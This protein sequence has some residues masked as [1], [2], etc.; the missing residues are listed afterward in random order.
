MI[1]FLLE[2]KSKPGLCIDLSQSLGAVTTEFLLFRKSNNY[3][4]D[5]PGAFFSI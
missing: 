5:K 2:E 3:L 1:L 4:Y